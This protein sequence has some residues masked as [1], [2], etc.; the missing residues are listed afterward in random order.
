MKVICL[1]SVN[2]FGNPYKTIE[3]G[4]I[5]TCKNSIFVSNGMCKNFETYYLIETKYGEFYYEMGL[6]QELSIWRDLQIDNLLN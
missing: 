4:E 6:F 5:Y 3:V 1:S 2:K